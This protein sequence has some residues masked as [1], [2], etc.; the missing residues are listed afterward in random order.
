LQDTAYLIPTRTGFNNN[1]YSNSPIS[2]NSPGLNRMNS[3]VYKKRSYIK[4]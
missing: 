2:T 3:N 4:K 1:I